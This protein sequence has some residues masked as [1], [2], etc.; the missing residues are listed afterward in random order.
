MN[1]TRYSERYNESI[2]RAVGVEWNAYQEAKSEKT[3][4]PSD[5]G[6]FSLDGT[7]LGKRVGV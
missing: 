3:Y 7:E 4:L 2:T 1:N 5:L 6:V